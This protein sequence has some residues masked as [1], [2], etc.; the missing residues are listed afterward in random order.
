MSAVI[1]ALGSGHALLTAAGLSCNTCASQGRDLFTHDYPVRPREERSHALMYALGLL[2]RDLGYDVA[3]LAAERLLD[4]QHMS[5]MLSE[6]ATPSA[7]EKAQESA[8]WLERNCER[9]V[10][11][12]DAAQ[13]AAMS[14]R[15]FSRH[16]KRQMGLTP[17]Q[18][19]LNARI[20]L[21]CELLTNSELPIDKIARRTGLSS[22]ERL[23]KLFRKQFSMSPA[24]Y[25][26]RKREESIG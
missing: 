13:T 18:Y 5:I 19:L 4:N 9:P 22:G 21:S 1:S 16:F 11:V 17:S 23:S 10:S 8:R 2:K 6:I 25:R 24:E 7:A 20:K 14:G 15:N 26:A 12:I 3:S